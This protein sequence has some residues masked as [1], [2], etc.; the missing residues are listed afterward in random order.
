MVWTPN[1]HF[2]GVM[3]YFRQSRLTSC[4]LC[5][6]LPNYT[7]DFWRF[8]HT[9]W[10]KDPAFESTSMKCQKGFD[11]CSCGEGI[12]TFSWEEECLAL[13]QW[14]VSWKGLLKVLF[15]TNQSTFRII[16]QESLGV[17]FEESQ[18]RQRY[19]RR[20]ASYCP[21]RL[22]ISLLR[23]LKELLEAFQ[24]SASVEDSKKTLLHW[25]SWPRDKM[26]FEFLILCLL[27]D[28]GKRKSWVEHWV[29]KTRVTFFERKMTMW[30]HRTRII[31]H[32]F[33]PSH[34]SPFLGSQVD[35]R[36]LLGISQQCWD[37]AMHWG[38]GG[39]GGRNLGL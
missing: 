17:P 39:F 24:R 15:F 21:H 22:P 14:K 11:R 12:S 16:M 6:K 34:G 18:F 32:P 1:H 27:F 28:S 9:P 10:Q 7:G 33:H 26:V 3:L 2:L 35:G 4:V 29:V 25:F 8:I 20:W 31:S 19:S 36:G 5:Y 23:L 30:V 37:D 13:A 38:W